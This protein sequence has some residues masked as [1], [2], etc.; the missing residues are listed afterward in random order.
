MDLMYILLAIVG[1][2]FLVF[3]HELGHY[4]L[5]KRAGMKIEIFSIGF[6]RPLISWVFQGVKWQICLLP[7]GG[8]VKIAGMQ[9]EGKVEP[10]DVPDG[11]YSK[12]PGKR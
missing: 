4:W 8:Y 12:S 9:R 1:L 7:F 10:C 5:A 3:I 11:F 2:G 6:G